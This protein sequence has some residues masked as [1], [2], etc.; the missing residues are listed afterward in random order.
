MI[1]L[2][3]TAQGKPW[4]DWAQ[5][6]SREAAVTHCARILAEGDPG[7]EYRIVEHT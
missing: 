2:R 4:S 3:N 7:Y 1:Q 6:N 5:H